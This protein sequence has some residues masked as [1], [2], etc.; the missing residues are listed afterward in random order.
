VSRSLPPDP[1]SQLRPPLSVAEASALLGQ[2]ERST[3]EDIANGLLEKQ[4]RGTSRHFYRL[5]YESVANL[6]AIRSAAEPNFET[7][8]LL[9]ERLPEYQQKQLFRHLQRLL[10]EA[11]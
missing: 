9:A 7:A 1:N 10:K 11:A 3:R 8:K 4:Y 2:S 6:V 5:T